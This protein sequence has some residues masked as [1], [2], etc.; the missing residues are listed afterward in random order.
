MRLSSIK[1]VNRAVR[2]NVRVQFIVLYDASVPTLITE[3]LGVLLA[4]DEDVTDTSPSKGVHVLYE[5][6]HWYYLT[7]ISRHII[8]TP[9]RERSNQITGRCGFLSND[10]IRIAFSMTSILLS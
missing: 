6:A 4:I 3:P 5:H 9:W 10:N 8:C 7:R 1:P 2:T